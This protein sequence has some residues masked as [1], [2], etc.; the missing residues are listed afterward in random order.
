MYIQHEYLIGLK[1]RYLYLKIYTIPRI[2]RY[3][4]KPYTFLIEKKDNVSFTS[5]H[6]IR[7]NKKYNT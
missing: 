3:F 7:S 1:I 6:L 5:A 2:Y 4:T